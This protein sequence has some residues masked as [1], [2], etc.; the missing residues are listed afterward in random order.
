MACACYING[1]MFTVDLPDVGKIKVDIRVFSRLSTN[2]PNFS[3]RLQAH[4]KKITEMAS[5]NGKSFGQRLLGPS[6]GNGI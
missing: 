2:I 4:S 1:D 6:K 3:L 5:E